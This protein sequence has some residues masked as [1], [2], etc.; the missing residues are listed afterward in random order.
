MLVEDGN[1]GEYRPL[2]NEFCEIGTAFIRAA[3]LSDGKISFSSAEKI[4]TDATLRI[5]KGVGKAGDVLISHKGTLGKIGFAR[6]GSPPFV[7]SPQTTFWRVLNE[8]V[9]DRYYLFAYMRSPQFKR[10]FSVCGGETD[11][12]PYVSLTSQRS[13]ELR[14]PQ[15]R[16]QRAIGEI[17]HSLDDKIELNRKTNETLEAMAKAL[18]KS[19]FVDFDPVRAKAEGR[20]T[21]LPAEISDLFP[22]S[23]EDSELGEIP[24]GWQ[25]CSFTKL[26]DVISGGTPK[27]S[28]DEYWNGSI[29]WFSVVDA[30]PGSSCW[31]IQTE[32]RIT[33]EGLANCSSKLLPTGT[34]IISARGTVGKV[35]LAGRDMAMNQS[36]YGLRSKAENGE[37]FC[38]Y[39]TKSLVEI[40]EA[41][42]HGSVFSTITRDT[43]DGVA[44]ISP[45]LEA[46]QSFNRSSGALLGKIK[47]NL[48]ENRI[49][50][51]QRDALLPKLISGELRIP[52]AEKMLEEVGV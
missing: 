37:F 47:T 27:T 4:N 18:F 52:D 23:F 19:W 29:P 38:F 44:T 35:C 20:S 17:V 2:K 30:P 28:I 36:C 39:L 48:E 7:C 24:C 9:I 31:V 41:R 25:C 16:I 40:L 22:D 5:R 45:S 13:I 51:N 1:H 21:G 8:Q 46:I 50:G 11:M 10:V 14:L 43:L 12:A 32:K 15:I 42:A 26:V 3:D 6:E 34:T 49:L 33:P